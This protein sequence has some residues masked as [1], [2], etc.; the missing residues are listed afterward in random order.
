MVYWWIHAISLLVIYHVRPLLIWHRIEIQA[1]LYVRQVSIVTKYRSLLIAF[2]IVT[3]AVVLGCD[4]W[5]ESTQNPLGAAI[6]N[7]FFIVMFIVLIL[8]I[9]LS[10]IQLAQTMKR[11]WQQTNDIAHYKFVKRVYF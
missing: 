5:Y 9:T 8:M 1:T 7:I 2:S 6:Y 11:A 10:G 4:L 3:S